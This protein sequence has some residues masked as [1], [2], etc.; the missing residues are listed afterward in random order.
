MADM[1]QGTMTQGKR[2]RGKES[3][4]EEELIKAEKNLTA[5]ER[6]RLLIK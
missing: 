5:A 2:A 6:E 4:S 1:L 3:D